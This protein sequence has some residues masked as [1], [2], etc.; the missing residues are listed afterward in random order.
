MMD[1]DIISRAVA[2]RHELHAHPELSMQETWT[3]AHLMDFLRANTSLRVVDCGRW[4]YACYDAGTER[5]AIA[6]RADFDALPVEEAPTLCPYA[7]TVPGVSHKCG[8][9]GHSA[10]LAAFA[11]ELDRN[12]ANQNICLVF[13][14]A[15]ETG[16]GARE[17]VETLRTLGI[18]EIYGV[19]NLPGLRLGAIAAPSGTAQ[20][21]ST[22]VVL[23]FEGA[24]SH[25][26]YPENGRNPAFA[27]A[28]VVLALEELRRSG[29]YRGM[30]LITVIEV[31]VGE[32]AF[33]TSAGHGELLLTVRAADGDELRD[34]LARIEA[35][36]RQRA[37][38]HGLGL[39]VSF[40]DAFPD[41]TNDPACAAK[42]RRAAERANVPV[43]ELRE[44]F[45]ASEDFGWYTKFL[46][47]AIFYVG[48]GES[49]A[50]IHTMEYDFPDEIIP[51]IAEM[52]RSI[53]ELS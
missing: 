22:G 16:K 47:G 20:F 13:Q 23:T 15:E 32:R 18:S 2:L 38:A 26:C 36:A 46:P 7:S 19:H 4:F 28:E 1:Q 33:G 9:D 31:Q 12:G 3:K 37:E 40:D 27:I 53:L 42:V 34:L 43:E 10:A 51:V 17:C 44:P 39:Q 45:R 6:F 8:H 41:T 14:H 11:M 24:K 21:A 30:T 25:A 48:A 52:Y 5:P 50:P 35:L 29:N 49:H